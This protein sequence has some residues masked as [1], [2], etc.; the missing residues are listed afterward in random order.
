VGRPATLPTRDEADDRGV[1]TL[2]AQE[3]AGRNI[4]VLFA[5]ESQALIVDVSEGTDAE[6]VAAALV[7][8]L[9][10][11][12]FDD[13]EGRLTEALEGRGGTVRRAP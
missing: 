9:G 4:E 11:S 8:C 6:D 5:D 10:A 7:D 2:R 12:T 13:A 1:N 3:A